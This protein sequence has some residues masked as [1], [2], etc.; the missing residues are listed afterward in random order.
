MYANVHVLNT[1]WRDPELQAILRQADIVYCDGAGVV[2]GA[3][4]L[5]HSLPERMTGADWVYPFCERSAAAG[6][7]L[8]FLGSAPGVAEQAAARLRERYPGL[9]IVGA[10]HGYVQGPDQS[11][12]VIADISRLS[13]DVLLVGMG[14]PLQEKWIAAHRSAL[15]VPVCWAV[16][17]LFD[18]VAGVVP[19]GPRWMLDH[20]LEWLYRLWWEPRRL[21][22]RY[23]IGNPLFLFRVLRQKAFRGRETGA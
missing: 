21:G 18:Y 3:R 6:L 13:P 11:A 1:A 17:A 20:G 8:Y 14:T 22:G 5:G 2:L 4:V 7:R 15:D 23:L 10:H 9:R 19:R 16:G 12:A